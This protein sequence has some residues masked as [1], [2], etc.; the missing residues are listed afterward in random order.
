MPR[1]SHSLLRRAWWLPLCGGLLSACASLPAP[2]DANTDANTRSTQE[3]P[4]TSIASP[5]TPLSGE[6][7][8]RRVLK[9]IGSLKSNADLTAEH[10]ERHTG[11]RMQRADSGDGSFGAGAAIDANWSY[12]LLVSPKLG[13]PRQ[14]LTFDF[15]R[16]GDPAAPMTPVCA[17][18]FDAYASALKAMGFQ[19]SPTYAEHGRLSYWNF[20][21]PVTLRVFVEGESNDSPEAI[22]HRCVKTITVE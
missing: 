11:L 4:M 17:L 12:N 7:V 1:P 9:L 19:D 20:R 8:S 2:S 10:L 21:G 14:Q 3:F 6:D 5:S 13:E 22:G 15:A 16:T 18:D